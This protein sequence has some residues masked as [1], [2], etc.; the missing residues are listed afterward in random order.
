VH[1]EATVRIALALVSCLAVAAAPAGA[2]LPGRARLGSVQADSIRRAIEKD[3]EDTREWLKG[4]ATSYLATVQRVDFPGR[5]RLIVGSDRS[6]N[7]RLE[8]AGIRPLHLGIRVVGD[9]FRVEALDDSARFRVKGVELRA[10][11]LPP[12]GLE[13]GRFLVRLSHQRYPAIIV[14]DPQS[15]RLRTYKG[16][17]YFP[18][19]LSWRFELPLTPNP[20]ADTVVIVSTR[21]SQRRAVRVGWF[22]FTAHGVR[23]RLE[24]DRL[25][26]PGVG[27]NDLAVFFRDRTTGS[28]TYPVGRYLDPVALGNGRYLL[29]FNQAYNP[30][31]AYSEHYNCPIPPRSNRLRLAVGAGEKDS[32]Y[33]EHSSAR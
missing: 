26:E 13:V 14:F 22:D 2:P 19:D 21:G 18:I 10:A 5:G 3:R 31:C 4:G 30:A 24:A 6:C 9:S 20:R 27:E 17:S 1:Q 25:L 29:D 15:P 28:D 7:V 8:G 32:H 12:S 16:I 33:L 11:T 23:C